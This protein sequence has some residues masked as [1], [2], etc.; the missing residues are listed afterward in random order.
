MLLVLLLLDALATTLLVAHLQ[1]SKL[2]LSTLLLFQL[3]VLLAK[4]FLKLLL[5]TMESYQEV[6]S[7]LLLALQLLDAL[8]LT[9]LVEF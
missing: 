4:P 1:T 7:Q 9:L 6:N 3:A 8:A 5:A 2:E